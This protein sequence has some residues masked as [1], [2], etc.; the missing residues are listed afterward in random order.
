[1]R[2][3]KSQGRL[4]ANPSN[5]SAAKAMAEASCKLRV[6]ARHRMYLFS[7][8]PARHPRRPGDPG[9][10]PSSCHRH[11]TDAYRDTRMSGAGG[12]ARAGA[13]VPRTEGVGGGLALPGALGRGQVR[14]TARLSLPAVR[15]GLRLFVSAARLAVCARLGG[16]GKPEAANQHLGLEKCLEVWT[17]SLET[18]AHLGR[19]SL[20]GQRPS[21]PGPPPS[22]T[23]TP[24]RP[25]SP[26]PGHLD[27]VVLALPQLPFCICSPA[28]AQ[29][30]PCS[31]P[32]PCGPL[33]R[34]HLTLPLT[35]P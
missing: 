23:P 15:A 6:G 9:S 27:L 3:H 34:D 5:H 17:F 8:S 24:Y 30:H 26:L 14:T 10:L 2:F 22:P 1:M 7:A 16:V 29:T 18:L 20:P 21:L 32:P 28:R 4:S 19:T 12:G 33:Y 13:L 35:D 25:A 31:W 11:S